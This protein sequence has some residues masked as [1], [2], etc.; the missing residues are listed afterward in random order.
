MAA[1]PVCLFKV[2]TLDHETRYDA[3]KHRSL[4]TIAF[5]SSGQLFEV[6]CSFRDDV[7]EELYCEPTS[8]FSINCNI[9]ED[10]GSCL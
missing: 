4:V 1:S 9:K 3:V 7:A 2:P 6:L 8:R 10:F 5:F